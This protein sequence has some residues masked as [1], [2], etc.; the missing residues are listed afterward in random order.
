MIGYLQ[1]TTSRCQR[2]WRRLRASAVV[3]KKPRPLKLHVGCG[4]VHLKDWVH[5]D[6]D[7]TLPHIDAIWYSD[8]GL[9][10]EDACCA[11][12]YSEHFLEHLTV[13][14]GLYFLKECRRALQPGGTLRI[15]MPDMKECVRQYWEGDWQKQPW[16]AKYRYD[17]IQTGC[18]MLNICFR[19]WEHK[20]LYDAQELERRMREAGFENIKPAS[21]H[22]SEHPE[23]RGLE[24]RA[25]SLLI[26]EASVTT[27]SSH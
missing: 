10:C 15:A 2:K 27:K 11:Y 7:P 5:L 23:L 26:F 9:P 14:Q 12:I 20:W 1:K 22:E 16:L 24:T 19:E 8:D 18:E 21:L 3:S 4:Q 25:E 13:P 6:A 17:W